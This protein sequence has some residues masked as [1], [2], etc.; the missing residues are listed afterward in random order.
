MLFMPSHLA[1]VSPFEK[2]GLLKNRAFEIP[3]MAV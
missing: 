3:V 2:P 1:N